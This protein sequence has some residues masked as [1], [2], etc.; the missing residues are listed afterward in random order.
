[1]LEDLLSKKPL[2]FNDKLRGSLPDSSG[3]YRIFEAG[4]TIFESVYVGE[5]INLKNRIH[6]NHLMGN[7]SASTLKRKHI[8][9][10]KFPNENAVKNYLKQKCLVQYI[11]VHDDLERVGFEHFVISLLHPVNND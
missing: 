9:E 7:R 5:S 3:I 6:G 4:S 2:P 1:M 11:L 8:A 10:N